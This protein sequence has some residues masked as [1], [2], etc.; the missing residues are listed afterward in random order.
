MFLKVLFL[1][2]IKI[3]EGIVKTTRN[4]T[5]QAKLEQLKEKP[6]DESNDAIDNIKGVISNLEA[7]LDQAKQKAREIADAADQ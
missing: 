4:N 2:Q 6:Q 7:K 5:Q 1:A 3:G